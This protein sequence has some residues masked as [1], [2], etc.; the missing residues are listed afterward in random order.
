MNNIDFAKNILLDNTDLSDIKLLTIL[1]ST[2]KNKINYSDI[3][4]QYKYQ[5]SWMLENNII[6]SAYYNIDKG[7]SIRTFNKKNI[8]FSYSDKISEKHLYKII[9]E[10]N[11]NQYN[12]K[13]KKT[14]IW[15]KIN[16]YQ[17]SYDNPLLSISN[18]EK[19]NL[20]KLIKNEA[21]KQDSRVKKI[22]CLL[23]GS[24]EIILIISTE[25]IFT[26]DIRPLVNLNI[27]IIAEK[28]KKYE[29]SN[30][31][32]SKRNTYD[33]L[34]KNNNW[35]KYTTEAVKKSIINLYS[36]EYSEN[37]KKLIP[38]IL[39]PGNP[40]IL[41]H[42]VIGHGL[43]ADF[44]R[45]KISFFHDKMNKK[46]ATNL[47]TIVDNGSLKNKRGS[48]N[49]DDEG[50]KTQCTTIIENGILK[51]YL[52]DK[53]NAN[54]MNAKLTG[55]ARRESY[56]HIPI[57]RMTNTYILPG[58]STHKEIINNVEN[59]IYISS[60]SK[61]QIKINSG[62]FI[63]FTNEA[64]NIKHGK[65]TYPI[66]SI[67]LIGN[68]PDILKKIIMIGNNLK[69]TSEILTCIKNNQ[70]IP[71]CVGQPTILINQMMVYKNKK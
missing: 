29:I 62:N 48:L 45:K 52:Q 47:C 2:L 17:N 35:K 70:K 67:K 9:K 49:I 5:E 27:N 69:I 66:K 7:I 38:V 25:G 61:C 39:G 58:K 64:Y 16:K 24:Y 63:F 21:K 44:N 51:S 4:F 19:I 12:D 36:I 34:L 37:S 46:I 30:Y 22:T 3:Y 18:E 32:K 54:L 41:I 28:N 8:N 56:K 23:S 13:N 26:A 60:F 6:K 53:I 11:I 10:S 55:N 65:I 71:I 33:I 50:T 59:G 43:E 1:N 20:L 40:G 15:K 42:E 31:S 14:K 68:G 57:P